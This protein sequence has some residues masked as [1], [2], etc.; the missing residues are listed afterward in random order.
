M[1]IVISDPGPVADESQCIN[2]LFEAGM[3]RF[4]LR[5]PGWS[6]NAVRSLLRGINPA[7]HNRIALHQHHSLAWE[8]GLQRLHFTEAARQHISEESWQRLVNSDCILST[9][10]HSLNEYPSL[11]PLFSYAFIGPVFNS[12]SK[13]G[14]NADNLMNELHHVNKPQQVPLIAIGG[15]TAGN[16]HEPLKAGCKGVAVLGTIWQNEQ[17]V[18]VYNHL[19]SIMLSLYHL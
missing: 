12:I 10:L 1:L 16:C 17:P 11:S 18:Q 19:S 13:A 15:I 4:H 14:Y 8:L 2:L 7:Y 6:V 5:K 9:S 3:Q